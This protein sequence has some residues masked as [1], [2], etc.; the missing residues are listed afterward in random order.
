MRIAREALSKAARLAVLIQ[1]RPHGFL[2][3]AGE[4]N[5]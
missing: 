2:Q 4:M 1:D 5:S 3:G